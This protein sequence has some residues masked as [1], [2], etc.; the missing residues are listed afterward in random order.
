MVAIS[1]LP[2][3]FWWVLSVGDWL[4]PRRGQSCF[5]CCSGRLGQGCGSCVCFHFGLSVCS[6]WLP[7]ALGS[8]LVCQQCLLSVR[9]ARPRRGFTLCSVCSQ[10]GTG[11]VSLW[12]QC[13]QFLA[14]A[15]LQYGSSA[16]SAWPQWGL[17]LRSAWA[18]CAFSVL[19]GWFGRA[20]G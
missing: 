19:P 3:L 6:A 14:L 15:C 5:W 11:V 13:A 1:L 2:H 12:L 8:A 18:L 10:R 17:V 4:S 7:C 9:S 16:L 20:P